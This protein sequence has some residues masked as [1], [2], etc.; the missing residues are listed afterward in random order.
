VSVDI[1]SFSQRVTVMRDRL[2]QLFEHA[3]TSVNSIPTLTP[4]AFKELGVA[5]EEL[6]VAVEE[7]R[8]QNEELA[9]ALTA[10]ALERQRYQ[11]LF[12]FA[13]EAY[14]VT[15]LT[16]I[17]QEVNQVAAQVLGVSPVFLVG[18]PL[19]LFVSERDRQFFRTKLSRQRYNE[20]PKTWNI[21]VEPRH[22]QPFEAACF[23]TVMRNPDDKPVGLRWLLKNVATNEHSAN[24]QSNGYNS[25]SDRT[26][27]LT[28]TYPSYP[29]S[30]GEMIPLEPEVLWQVTQGLVKLT[31]LTENS[32]DILLGLSG[33][34]MVFGS[35]LIGLPLYQ[36]IAL[37]D[38]Q[39]ISIPLTEINNSPNLAQTLFT[40]MSQRLRQTEA[41]LALSGER[42]VKNRLY[43]LLH[44]LKQEVGQP[45][46]QG[47][48]L[49]VRLTHE[50]LASAC[51]STR[52]TITRLMGQ[53]QQQGKLILDRKNHIILVE[54]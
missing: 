50:D 18:K 13:P 32:T 26:T 44:L 48:R 33:P 51:C 5:S 29:Y 1:E 42:L 9:A 6:Q 16:G 11:D 23:V 36:A 37:S 8:Q 35:P 52:T 45:T 41:L 38:V 19:P 43:R 54:E 2:A 27:I 4:S 30:R 10:V 47:T 17:I 24:S 22:G 15:D 46:T 40:Q 39:L 12:E 3:T 7:L 20:P 25:T 49:T 53:L 31:T 21:W 34:G 28:S 14:L